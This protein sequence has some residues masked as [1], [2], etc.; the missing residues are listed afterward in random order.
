MNH[1]SDEQILQHI[2]EAVSQITPD[3]VDDL[4][5]TYFIGAIA[6][7]CILSDLHI[8]VSDYAFRLCILRC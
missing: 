6:A 4:R 7:C 1:I 2:S 3:K 5:K 8:Y